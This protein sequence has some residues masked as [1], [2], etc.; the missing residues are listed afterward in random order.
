[1]GQDPN[2]DDPLSPQPGDLL[3]GSLAPVKPQL[4]RVDQQHT[5]AAHLRAKQRQVQGQGSR[6][7][8]LVRRLK[9]VL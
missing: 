9:F 5:T 7:S 8:V 2:S 4:L 6:T 1:M 3:R